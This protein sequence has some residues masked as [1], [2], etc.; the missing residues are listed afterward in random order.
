MQE[1]HFQMSNVGKSLNR[2]TLT[3]NRWDLLFAFRVLKQ[4]VHIYALVYIS[5]RKCFIIFT[6]SLQRDFIF[7]SEKCQKLLTTAVAIHDLQPLDHASGTTIQTEQ[8]PTDITAPFLY[9]GS[10]VLR[11]ACVH[12]CLCHRISCTCVTQL[13]QCAK[14]QC[15]HGQI[16]LFQSL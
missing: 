4:M 5:F 1:K 14:T 6:C 3:F 11:T 12:A 10:A 16:I 7:T 8:V 9:N 2:E 13:L 15:K